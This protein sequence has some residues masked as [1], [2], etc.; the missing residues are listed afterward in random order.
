M[1][2]Y[3]KNIKVSLILTCYNCKN[4]LIGTLKSITNQ[5]YPKLEIV[6]IDG[7]STDGTV[8]IIKNFAQ[9]YAD[10]YE[11]EWISEKDN[12]I[13]DAMNKG[14]RLSTGDIIAFFNDKFILGVL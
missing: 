14:F 6:I 12:G 8:D 7:G 10:K 2:N 3:K 9:R 5:T 11:I 4:N 1:S 13:Y